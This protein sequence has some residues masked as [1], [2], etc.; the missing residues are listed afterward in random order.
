M[1]IQLKIR[2]I[3]EIIKDTPHELHGK[4]FRDVVKESY[5]EYIGWA[6][7]KNANWCYFVYIIKYPATR[8][9]NLVGI[10]TIGD[11]IQ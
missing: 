10:V 1:N 4:S 9:K 6:K 7:K 11:I 3:K 8:Y 5:G 2:D